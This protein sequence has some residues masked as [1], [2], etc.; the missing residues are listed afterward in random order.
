MCP[1]VQ[2]GVQSLLEEIVFE[3][4]VRADERDRRGGQA[5]GGLANGGQISDGLRLAPRGCDPVRLRP[6]QNQLLVA[7]DRDRRVRAGIAD[8]RLVRTEAVEREGRAPGRHLGEKALIGNRAGD[9][10][11]IGRVLD[12]RMDKIDRRGRILRERVRRV[13]VPRAEH[14]LYAES[15][16]TNGARP[17]LALRFTSIGIESSTWELRIIRNASA[18]IVCTNP[19]TASFSPLV[20]PAEPITLRIV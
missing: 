19:R 8:P 20:I 10:L 4:R 14:M 11:G 7:D 13:L 9:A 2:E 12:E 17:W 18:W 15:L 3:H 1:L 6:Q 5:A 16:D